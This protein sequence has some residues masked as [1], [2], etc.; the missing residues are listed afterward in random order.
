MMF[1]TQQIQSFGGQKLA[2]KVMK[3]IQLMDI[4]I[5]GV[6]PTINFFDYPIEPMKFESN[7]DFMAEA[8]KVTFYIQPQTT[9]KSQLLFDFS[10]IYN[11]LHLTLI[12]I[13]CLLVFRVCKIILSI[14]NKNY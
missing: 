11:I 3:L 5:K 9:Y 10:P 1:P 4:K 12:F 14:A 6:D 13:V 2:E 7:H 8:N